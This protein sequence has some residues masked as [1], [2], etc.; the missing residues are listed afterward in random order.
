MNDDHHTLMVWMVFYWTWYFAEGGAKVYFFG[1]VH[2]I[3]TLNSQ[4]RILNVDIFNGTIFTW[5]IRHK[6]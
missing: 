4:H 2:I 5:K 3:I 6:T 1:Q